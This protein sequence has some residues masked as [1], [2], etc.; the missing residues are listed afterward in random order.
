M[1]RSRT[2]PRAGTGVSR[3]RAR[4]R[5]YP[6]RRCWTMPETSPSPGCR[7]AIWSRRPAPARRPADQLRA[8]HALPDRGRPG[9]CQQPGLWLWRL[10]RPGRRPVQCRPITAMPGAII[11]AR[12]AAMAR[13]C[14]RAGRG[15]SGPGYPPGQHARTASTGPLAARRRHHHLDRHAIRSA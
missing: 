13:R 12:R 1:S 15:P 9:L 8:R 5:T 3:A 2:G 6:P 11:S 7:P 14:A 4:S 10:S